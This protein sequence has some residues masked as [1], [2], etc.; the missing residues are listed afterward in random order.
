MK[1]IKETERKVL[2]FHGYKGTCDA[3]VIELTYEDDLIGIVVDET[4]D[5]LVIVPIDILSCPHCFKTI[6]TI[7]I[8]KDHM[9]EE[10]NKK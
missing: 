10:E 5:R 6:G 8:L 7:S 9:I 3:C 2:K 4:D 1:I